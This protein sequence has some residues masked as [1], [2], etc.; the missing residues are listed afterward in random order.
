MIFTPSH[1]ALLESV[2]E[3]HM[4]HTAAILNRTAVANQYGEQ[5]TTYT[6][7]WVGPCGEN[8]TPGKEITVNRESVQIDAV[9]RLPKVSEAYISQGDRISIT[10]R[11]GVALPTA[12]VYE[13]VGLPSHGPSGIQINAKI[14]IL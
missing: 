8:R 4:P 12:V 1:I 2:Q 14:E 6:S 7:V 5:E 13:A 9:L 11:F 3:A 10:H